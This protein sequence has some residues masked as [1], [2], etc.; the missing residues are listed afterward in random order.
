MAKHLEDSPEYQEMYDIFVQT[1]PPE[2]ARAMVYRILEPGG[3]PAQ[4]AQPAQVAQPSTMDTLQAL[5]D[6]IMGRSTTT[7]PDLVHP[8]MVAPPQP[9]GPVQVPSQLNIQE[10]IQ[11]RGVGDPG[12]TGYQ[13]GVPLQ[14]LGPPAPGAQPPI[15]G[16]QL[17]GAGQPRVI[18]I[19]P[20]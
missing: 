7:M 15:A 4:L 13:V 6:N 16:S 18:I 20:R 5:L 14:P 9:S 19:Q 3:R 17:R 10:Q 1:F 2:E 11:F 12:S 8:S